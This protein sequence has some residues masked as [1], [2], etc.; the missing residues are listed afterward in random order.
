MFLGNMIEKQEYSGATLSPNVGYILH[1]KEKFT[2][3]P[4]GPVTY[5]FSSRLQALSDKDSEF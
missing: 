4:N 5:I 2:A 3:I 1:V